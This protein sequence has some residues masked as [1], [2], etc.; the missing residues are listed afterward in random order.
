MPNKIPTDET[1]PLKIPD[2]FNSRY[3]YA[4]G[5]ILTELL[6]INNAKFLKND[7]FRPHNVYGKDMGEEHVISELIK[8]ANSKN[9]DM[10]IKGSGLETRSFIFIDDFLEAFY[11]IFKKESI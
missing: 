3:S 11:L 6:A 8:K 9:I 1:E 7:N 4:G 10:K 5:K 2:V